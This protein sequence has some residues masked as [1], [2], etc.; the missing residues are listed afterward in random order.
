VNKIK[1]VFRHGYYTKRNER[2]SFQNNGRF[3]VI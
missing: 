2:S 3:E 1:P